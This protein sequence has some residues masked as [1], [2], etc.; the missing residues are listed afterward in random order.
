MDK[1]T[2]REIVVASAMYSLG[3]IL[4]PLLLIGGTGL[5]LDK[6]LG[7]Y[8]WILLGSIL[9]AFIVTNVLLFKKI[10][11]INRLMDNYRQEI[12]SKKINEKET[13][14]EKGID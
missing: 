10:K 1:K 7:T 8:P 9:L 5:L 4:G 13:E 11:K 3:S 14:S 12:I 2:I 6:L